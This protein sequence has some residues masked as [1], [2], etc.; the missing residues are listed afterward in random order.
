MAVSLEAS[1]CAL[2]VVGHGKQDCIRSQQMGYL[3]TPPVTP[4]HRLANTR[5]LL[6]QGAFSN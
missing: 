5:A 4:D 2:L 1:L 3:V 6:P